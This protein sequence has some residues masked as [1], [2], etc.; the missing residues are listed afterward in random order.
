MLR[1]LHSQGLEAHDQRADL[2][3]DKDNEDGHG[4]TLTT[5]GRLVRAVT[6]IQ[7]VIAH[8]MLGD[9]LLILALE[10]CGITGL[11]VCYNKKTRNENKNQNK[12]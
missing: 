8:K 11:V 10:L 4:H 5:F 3:W 12:K 6:A 9:A 7:V 1:V 2:D